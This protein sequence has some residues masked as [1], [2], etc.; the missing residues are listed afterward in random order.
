MKRIVNINRERKSFTLIELLVVIAIIGILAAISVGTISSQQARAR[1][2]QRVADVN[3]IKIAMEKYYAANGKYPFPTVDYNGDKI[4][5]VPASLDSHGNYTGVDQP[6]CMHKVDVSWAALADALAP[7]LPSLPQD[8][9]LFGADGSP[10]PQHAWFVIVSGPMDNSQHYL[11]AYP[12]EGPGANN[13]ISS[14]GQITGDVFVTNNNPY[15][16][17]YMIYFMDVQHHNDET[18][19]LCQGAG[20]HQGG[21]A[22]PWFDWT[23]PCGATHYAPIDN[24]GNLVNANDLTYPRGT[25]YLGCTG[26]LRHVSDAAPATGTGVDYGIYCD[27]VLDRDFPLQCLPS[28]HCWGWT[29]DNANPPNCYETG[30]IAEIQS[31]HQGDDGTGHPTIGCLAGVGSGVHFIPHGQPGCTY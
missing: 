31:C 19:N 25:Y 8:P 4:P 13:I 7:Y 12:M 22:S 15:E 10:D 14:S 28:G 5:M 1:N 20:T 27:H 18:P 16:G 9:Q 2:A 17:D 21:I 11:I 24:S 29:C 6:W 26:S 3:K 30:K 23:V